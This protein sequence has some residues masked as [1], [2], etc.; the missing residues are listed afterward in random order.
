MIACEDDGGKGKFAV[1]CA[2]VCCGVEWSGVWYG[3][4][5]CRVILCCVV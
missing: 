3:G 4:V 5:S 2:V 1:S